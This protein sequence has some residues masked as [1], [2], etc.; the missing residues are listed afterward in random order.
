MSNEFLVQQDAESIG[1]RLIFDSL[2]FLR[3]VFVIF[4]K[5]LVSNRENT[6]VL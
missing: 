6:A 2:V 5:F 1:L 4:H 3:I